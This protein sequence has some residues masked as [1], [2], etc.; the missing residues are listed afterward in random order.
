MAKKK[1]KEE[2][3]LDCN[4]CPYKTF[5]KC[6]YELRENTDIIIVGE[7][8]GSEEIEHKPPKPFIGASGKL[9]FGTLKK[10]CGLY[11]NNVSIANALKCMGDNKNIKEFNLA[12][13]CCRQNVIIA[14]ERI[15]PKLIIAFGSNALKQILGNGQKILSKSGNFFWSEEFNC[16][17]L[18]SIHPSYA[19]RNGV[20]L[21]RLDNSST[22]SRIW[23]NTFRS[24]NQF[25]K[26][27][28]S[29]KKIDTSNYKELTEKD[30]DEILN[31]RVVAIDYETNGLNPFS[32]EVKLISLSFTIKEGK[33]RV[34]LDFERE[35]EFIKQVLTNPDITKV[36]ANRPFE[37]LFT[38][39]KLGYHIKGKVHDVLTMAHIVNEDNCQSYSLEQVAELYANMPNIKEVAEGQR[40]T[41]EN[42]DRD[43]IIRYN[44]V[45]TDATFRTYKKLAEILSKEDTLKRYYFKLI[46]PAQDMYAKISLRGFPIDLMYV[47]QLENE[48]RE[49]AEGLEKEA[50]DLLPESIK[51]KYKDKLR[52]TIPS[53]IIDYLFLHKDGLRF[54]P[55]EFTEKTG[56]PTTSEKHLKQFQYKSRFVNLLLRWKKANKI[57]STYFKMIY[58][59]VNP[60]DSKI[61]PQ[62]LFIATK[63][64][65]L[66][67]KNPSLQVIPQR[68]EFAPYI[69]KIFK[70]PEGYYIFER[71]L[72]QSE[73]RIM[74]W[75]ANCKNILKALHNNIDLHKQT[76]NLILGIPL[77]KVTKQQRQSCKAINFGFIYGAM[78]RTFQEVAK[79]DYGIDFTLEEA[80]KLREKYFKVYPE[81]LQFHKKVIS[82]ARRIG[83]V[84]SPLGRR[85]H[86]YNINSEDFWL[87][88]E[89]ERQAINFPIQSFSS[90]LNL[91]A[92]IL[93]EKYIRKEGLEDEIQTLFLIHDAMFGIVR[94]DKVKLA[95]WLTKQAME[96]WSK[97]YIKKYFDVDVDYPIASEF[98]YG[99]SWDD[100]KEVEDVFD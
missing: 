58:E 45:D 69:K 90:D 86:L 22:A 21:S 85:R 80:T 13:K 66:V 10:V 7:A 73:L 78:P 15:K 84:S 68:G 17:V 65:R 30:K 9:L 31:S 57:L 8:P 28:Y 4:S 53:L 55:T 46:K 72:G 77:D 52:L 82:F 44:G 49:V 25:I 64:G 3:I 99:K 62:T 32:S 98:A 24:L 34:I 59:A 6:P 89:A 63:T 61:Y 41:L 67:I 5:I 54:K 56:L 93:L 95:Q 35:K 97:E 33:S 29:P 2:Q 20:S 79:N 91:I 39:K 38:Y 40:E 14:I 70:A 42:A 83:Y 76:A 60:E 1:K 47:R 11:R 100:L 48:L 19:L 37:E 27:G 50:L 92:Q 51:E 94:E 23:L 43:L 18:A 26:N 75:L 87:R 16:W 71:D 12:L 96:V 81:V 36:V 74:G 88:S